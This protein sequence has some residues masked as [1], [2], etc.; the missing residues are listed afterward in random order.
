[1][2]LSFCFFLCAIVLF[3]FAEARINPNQLKRLRELVRDDEPTYCIELG[4]RCPNPREG[5]WCCHKCVPEGKRF[6]CRDQ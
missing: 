4:E 3:S 1:M 6:Y 2:K 5:D